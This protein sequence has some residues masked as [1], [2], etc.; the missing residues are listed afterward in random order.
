MV[1]KGQIYPGRHEP[2]VTQELFDRV[3]DI[4]R[5]RS[6]N[7]SRD[8]VHNHY[9]KGFLFCRRCRNNGQT[10]RLVFSKSTGR[11]GN[12]YA[13]FVCRRSK[14]GDCDLPALPVEKVEEA[15][16]EHYRALPLPPD[17]AADTRALLDN[18]VADEQA[19]TYERHASLNRQLK[20][21]D[22]QENRLIDLL[23][24][25]TMP[26]AKVRHKLAEIK[27]KRRR[28]EA[29]LADTTEQLA[30]GT[31]VLRHALDLIENPYALYRDAGP[32]VRRRLN[33]TFYKRFYIDDLAGATAKIADEKTA[34]FADLHHATGKHGS[35]KEPGQST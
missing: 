6:A 29:G 15:V 13:Y 24:D 2:L 20:E 1:W 11:S 8:H 17:F 10:S 3:Q 23:A 7:G 25:G 27:N 16:T 5:Y 28:L 32:D 34:I 22:Q 31:S 18:I 4:L 35:P 26:Q 9:L 33:E 21:L 19:S 14:E 30:I 12:R